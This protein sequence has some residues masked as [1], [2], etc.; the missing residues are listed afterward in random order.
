[1]LFKKKAL[2]LHSDSASTYLTT[3]RKA[4]EPDGIL[5]GVCL[6]VYFLAF[7]LIM[8][9]QTSKNEANAHLFIPLQI[10]H[11]SKTCYPYSN[12]LE[13]LAY[14]KSLSHL[15][16]TVLDS[17]DYFPH[18]GVGITP[19]LFTALNLLLAVI[20]WVIL[21]S[22]CPLESPVHSLLYLFIVFLKFFFV[23]NYFSLC[24][25]QFLLQVPSCL[26]PFLCLSPNVPG[27]ACTVCS[28]HLRKEK[29]TPLAVPKNGMSRKNHKRDQAQLLTHVVSKGFPHGSSTQSLKSSSCCKKPPVPSS[30]AIPRCS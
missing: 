30:A 18:P 4:E 19:K 25:L 9:N 2:Y 8:K 14:Q 10:T 21:C 24:C 7:I 29:E 5:A 13:P 22:I 12:L 11:F 15:M 27:A 23:E 20:Q 3:S 16:T 26:C 1:M 6:F 28:Q 17:A